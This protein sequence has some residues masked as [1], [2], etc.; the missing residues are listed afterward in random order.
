[1]KTSRK[2][3][4]LFILASALCAFFSAGC[5]TVHGVGQDLDSAG[6]HIEHAANEHR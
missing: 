2:H 3:L 6:K 4:A 5:H 1:M